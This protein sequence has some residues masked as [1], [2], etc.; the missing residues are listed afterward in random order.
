MLF[1]VNIFA[2]SDGEIAGVI[3]LETLNKFL[4]TLLFISII[5]YFILHNI[6]SKIEKRLGMPDY[7]PYKFC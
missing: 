4:L 5:Q 1:Y 6:Q 7:D 3:I 2:K